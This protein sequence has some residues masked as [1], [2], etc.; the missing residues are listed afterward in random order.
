MTSYI[1]RRK[2]SIYTLGNLLTKSQPSALV[3]LQYSSL[4][5]GVVLPCETGTAGAVVGYDGSVGLPG[6]AVGDGAV[7]S[8]WAEGLGRSDG[9]AAAGEGTLQVG[10][11][12]CQHYTRPHAH[13]HSLTSGHLS[14][15]ATQTQE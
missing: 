7:W 3:S 12:A 2:K 11:H 8:G 10:S 15:R 9:S 1:K 14:L 4:A 13:A 6:F 5:I